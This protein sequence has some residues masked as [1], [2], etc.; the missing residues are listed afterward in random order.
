MAT[1]IDIQPYLETQK[2][3]DYL[4]S[5]KIAVQKMLDKMLMELMENPKK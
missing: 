5:D 1:I 2:Q 3:V 4:R